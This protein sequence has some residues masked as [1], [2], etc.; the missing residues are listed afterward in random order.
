MCQTDRSLAEGGNEEGMETE[1]QIKDL[2]GYR[3]KGGFFY[4]NMCTDVKNNNCEIDKVRKKIQSSSQCEIE[5]V[6]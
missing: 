2:N 5:C 6:V 4:E 1:K 3:K